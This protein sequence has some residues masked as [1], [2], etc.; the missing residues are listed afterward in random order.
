MEP[1]PPV[2]IAHLSDTHLGLEA[3]QARNVAGN[4]ARGADVVAAFHRAVTAVLEEDPPL[5]VHSGDVFESP[6]VAVRYLLAARREFE[7]LC[8]RRPDGT[9]RAV[10]V[11]AG[12]HDASRNLRDGCQLDLF[13]P[14]DNLFPVSS[15]YRQL[16]FDPADGFDP[17]LDNLVV[18][19]LPHDSLRD[20]ELLETVVPVTDARN[21]LVAHG[22]A[23]GDDTFKRMIGREFPI[24]ADV[25]VRPW[26]YVALGHWH[27]QTPVTVAGDSRFVHYAGSTE[28]M[29]FS[30]LRSRRDVSERAWLN[31]TLTDGPPQV[32]SRSFPTRRI[33]APDP[34]DATGMTPTQVA[35][36]LVA[37]LR[38][39]QADDAV[40][41]QR[42]TNL[43]RELWNIVDLTEVRAVAAS[44]LHHRI[45]P[46]YPNSRSGDTTNDHT[47][48][49]PDLGDIQSLL[50]ARLDELVPD[51]VR[52]EVLVAARR[53][54]GSQL[55]TADTTSDE[56]VEPSND[57][58]QAP[59]TTEAASPIAVGSTDTSAPRRNDHE[60]PADRY[61]TDGRTD[62]RTDDHL[63]T[64]DDPAPGPDDPALP[65]PPDDPAGVFADVLSEFDITT[66]AATSDTPDT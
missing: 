26:N 33:C 61:R 10:V 37:Q 55:A 66:I 56:P 21:V 45:E 44:C 5:V 48:D 1:R 60:D 30:D 31:V 49:G 23:E 13:A 54:L 2:R 6:A 43:T 20:A 34:I 22:V 46:V 19:A 40:V 36:A 25:L 4:N 58:S 8:A 14:I 17:S 32:V 3:H 57:A 52:A 59:D 47:D 24:P 15:T 50:L 12:N 29:D 38:D 11:I 65:S 28:C 35:D 51:A 63:T 7:R 18:H 39:L 16:R 42:V 64:H 41:R 9:R 27:T 62:G 53:L